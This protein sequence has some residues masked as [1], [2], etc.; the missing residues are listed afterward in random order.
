MLQWLFLLQERKGRIV[1]IILHAASM[2]FSIVWAALVL[3]L[4]LRLRRL[5]QALSCQMRIGRRDHSPET[6]P[7]PGRPVE[8][9]DPR[10][11]PRAIA[12]TRRNRGSADIE[13][14]LGFWEERAESPA[15]STA[16]VGQRDR[17]GPSDG[18]AGMKSDSALFLDAM[19]F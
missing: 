19:E 17:R 1:C 6:V 9:A 2:Q 15:I 4:H 7:Q 13:R 5:D 12:P 16:L 8:C 18:M 14:D 11:Y 3:A 10:T